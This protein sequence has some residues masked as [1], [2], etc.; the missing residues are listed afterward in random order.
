MGEG[1]ILVKN[2]RKQS[3]MDKEESMYVCDELHN[4]IMEL[5]VSQ[6]WLSFTHDS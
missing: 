1:E 5:D 3:K 2:L 6:N 4:E